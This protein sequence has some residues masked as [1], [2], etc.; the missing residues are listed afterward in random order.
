MAAVRFTTCALWLSCE[1]AEGT[2][3]RAAAG[4]RMLRGGCV[5]Y[6]CLVLAAVQ[7]V[8]VQQLTGRC[9]GCVRQIRYTA[10]ILP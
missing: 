2:G 6:E 8:S 10:T 7:G 3:R 1:L 4:G 5:P 9:G